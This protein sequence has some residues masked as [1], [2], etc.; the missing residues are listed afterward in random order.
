[1]TLALALSLSLK[2][3]AE[4][5]S[6]AVFRPGLLSAD[7]QNQFSELQVSIAKLKVREEQAVLRGL[8]LH[9]DVGSECLFTIYPRHVGVLK[10][11]STVVTDPFVR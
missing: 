10:L 4:A 2:S 9:K 6:H 7:T 8:S 1:L 3:M 11:Q 5:K